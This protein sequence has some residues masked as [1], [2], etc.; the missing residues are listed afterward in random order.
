MSTEGVSMPAVKTVDPAFLTELERFGAF[1][2]KACFNCGNCTATCPQTTEAE[3]FPRR[4]IRLAQIGDRRALAASREL[5]LCYYCGECSISCRRKAEPGELMASA[6]RFAISSFDITGLARL[7]YT[8]WLANII[9]FPLVALVM[10]WFMLR[11]AGPVNGSFFEFIPGRVIHDIGVAVVVI[12]AITALLGLTNM[13]RLIWTETRRRAAPSQKKKGLIEWVIGAIA[14]VAAEWALQRRYRACSDEYAVRQPWHRARWLL[15][16]CILWGFMGLLLATIL[17]FLFKPDYGAWVP[18]WYPARLIGTLAGVLLVYGTGMMLWQRIRPT[19]KY[20]E[21]S[22]ITDWAFL[23]ILF[24]LGITGFI[25]EVLDYVAPMTIAGNMVLLFHIVL[26]FTLIL[27][28]PFIKFAHIMY[29]SLAL[30]VHA[31]AR[32]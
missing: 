26:V 31:L 10:L 32:E 15:H 22:L 8:S 7:L 17:D 24:L 14:F 3:S 2:A 27:L 6:R 13:T 16:W 5:W 12:T 4:L 25:L 9:V 11:H 18:L 28:F 20:A 30:F 1:D 23:T 21:R 29:R 19:T